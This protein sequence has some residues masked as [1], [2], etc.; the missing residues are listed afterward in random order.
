MS[1]NPAANPGAHDGASDAAPLRWLLA[2]AA[3][4]IATML[5]FMNYSAAL[6][7]IRATWSLSASQA[8]TIFAGQQIGYTLAVLVL[9][10]LTDRIGV[11]RI[12]LASAAL[13][14]LG[15]LLFAFWARD[16]WT[17]IAAR[18]VIGAGLA[19]TYVP[20]M[21]LVVERS[22][23][24]RRG[25]A[26]GI[27]ISCFS[28]GSAASL[29]LTGA[30]LPTGLQT[31]FAVTAL[32]PLVAA[33]VAG[34]L[35]AE[36]HRVAGGPPPPP[37]RAVL[38]NTR[39]M[40][41]ILAYAAHNWELF[42]MRTW[43]PA[44]LAVAWQAAGRPLRDAAVLGAT[45]S[46]A[47]LLASAASNAGGGWLSDRLGRSRTIRVFLIG[48]AGCSFALGWM[49]PWGIP[50]VL[51]VA[52][53]YGILVTAD[54]ST[55]STAV[56]ESAEPGALG[57]TLAVQSALGFIVTAISPALF[58]LILDAT[59]QWGWAFASL[60]LAAL[61]GVLATPVRDSRRPSPSI[62]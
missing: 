19:G 58:G 35:L 4:E 9:S 31:A 23:T 42:G 25:A 29:A 61:L 18:A 45:V 6:P 13:N 50:I 16:F 12:Y 34:P 5:S 2:L 36:P 1:T 56:A 3:V 57:R 33:A 38:R 52:L 60:G 15:G 51:G 43:M 59:A 44:F 27:Y 10:S 14:G 20:G 55:I 17:A 49:L 46:G 40:R 37:V 11:R 30:L 53:L 48:S 62:Q 24:A 41:F 21:R 28:I 39:A 8:G 54:S 26:L 22:P 47:M 7:I 32:G